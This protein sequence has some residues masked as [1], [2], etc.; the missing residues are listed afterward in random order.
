MILFSR[1]MAAD[2]NASQQVIHGRIQFLRKFIADLSN[3]TQIM[4]SE[5]Q[6]R[7]EKIKEAA[8]CQAFCEKELEGLELRV[9]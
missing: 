2:T 8:L 3:V 6:E 9:V 1:E 4:T 5:I 7:Q